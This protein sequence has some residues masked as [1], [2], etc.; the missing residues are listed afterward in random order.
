MCINTIFYGVASFYM[1]LAVAV[2]IG[3]QNGRVYMRNL[4]ILLTS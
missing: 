1:L 3:A 2:D 4:E